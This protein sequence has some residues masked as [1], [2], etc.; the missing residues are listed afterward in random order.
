M[1]FVQSVRVVVSTALELHALTREGVQYR[2]VV[3]PG[4]FYSAYTAT[5]PLQAVPA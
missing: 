2:R 4:R 1:L 5:V 3:G